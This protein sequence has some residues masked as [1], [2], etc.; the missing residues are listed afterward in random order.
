MVE[1]PLD[2]I[3]SCTVLR[4]LRLQNMAMKTVP[5]SV[6]HATTLNRLDLSCNRITNLDD[7]ALDS[8]PLKSLKLQNN[9]M[10]QLP[11]YFPRLRFLQELNI[12]NNKFR[13]VPDVV[14]KIPSL[15]DLDISFNMIS[16]LPSEIGNLTSLEKLIL[17]GNQISKFPSTCFSWTNLQNLDCR[18]NNISD[19]SLVSV[20]PKVKTILADH[21]VIHSLTLSFGPSLSTLDASHNHITL[22]TAPSAGD[23]YF[24]MTRLDISHAKL[25]TLDNLGLGQLAS[26]RELKVDHN[27]IRSLP[28]SVGELSELR[29]LSCSN[30]QLYALP[31]SLGRLQML[32]SL[33]AHNNS[34]EEL[35]ASIWDC[36]LLSVI[37]LTS[38]LIKTIN[39]PKLRDDAINN[40]IST[41]VSAPSPLM[42]NLYLERKASAASSIGFLTAPPLALS[43]RKLY[44]GENLLS[45]EHLHLLMVLKDLKVLN[46][47]FNRIQLI[48]PLFLRSLSHLEEL[49]LSGNE[50]TALPNAELE[51]LV[52]LRILFLNGNKLQSLPQELAKI[53]SLTVLD[54]GSN[55]LRYNMHN[56]EFDY[57][58]YVYLLL[59][60]MIAYVQCSG[61]SICACDI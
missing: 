58:W 34:I 35:P 44:L 36:A 57:N 39:E 61:T 2:F 48:P 45:E 53:Q 55:L 9:G 51:A 37:N 32:T 16:E 19:L 20:L 22:L 18:R 30:N 49:Y 5:R 11:W 25:S 13:R 1:I 38:N 43:L 12:S 21:N 10:E 56:W 47:S 59:A 42:S 31:E 50:L 23:Q 27:S 28:E 26:L 17:V 29:H 8:I 15:V 41:T 33:E 14:C 54:V 40:L 46:L 4:E 3:Q 24:S 60:W 7:A 52:N 6:R